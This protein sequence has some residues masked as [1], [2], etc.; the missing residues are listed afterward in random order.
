[1]KLCILDRPT[2]C[3]SNIWFEVVKKPLQM[4]LGGLVE[5]HAKHQSAG[6]CES[7]ER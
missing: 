2:R 4:N 3:D 6:H 1:M 7:K 5:Q